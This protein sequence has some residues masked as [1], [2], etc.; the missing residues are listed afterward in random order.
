MNISSSH[1]LGLALLPVLTGFFLLRPAILRAQDVQDF[2]TVIV[3][4]GHGG[5]DRGGVPGQHGIA[6]KEATLDTARR[7]QRSLRAAACA[8]S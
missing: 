6:E 3:D 2:D 4:A 5:H 7:L 1:R 8:S